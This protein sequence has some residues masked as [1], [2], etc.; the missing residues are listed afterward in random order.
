MSGSHSHG[1]G[2]GGSHS[3]GGGSGGDPI[4]GIAIVAFSFGLIYMIT[5]SGKLGR[6][7]FG[8]LHNGFAPPISGSWGSMYFNM[9]WGVIWAVISLISFLGIWLIPA[10]RRRPNIVAF[11]SIGAAILAL[12][13][14]GAVAA[15]FGKKLGVSPW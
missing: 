12:V 1:G 13:F 9:A 14:G 11:V 10:F 4:A 7:M 15:N 5:V 8:R 3:H 2:S 6:Y